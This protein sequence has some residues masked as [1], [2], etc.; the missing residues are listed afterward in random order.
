MDFSD[1]EA[2]WWLPDT[3]HHRTSG[4]LAYSASGLTLTV[5]G[6]LHPGVAPEPGVL[7][8]LF[9]DLKNSPIVHGETRTGQLMSLVGVSGYS[10]QMLQSFQESYRVELALEGDHIEEVTFAGIKASFQQLDVWAGAD[11]IYTKTL[12]QKTI[13]VHPETV[14]LVCASLQDATLRIKYGVEG[15]SHDKEVSY[16]RWCTY[17]AETSCSM[18]WRDL[19]EQYVQPLNDLLV[20]TMGSPIPLNDVALKV[21]DSWCPVYFRTRETRGGSKIHRPDGY[22]SPAILT[23]PTSPMPADQLLV[24]WFEIRAELRETLGVLLGPVYAP[25]TYE[26]HKFASFFQGLE[27][28]HSVRRTRYG[29]TD[30]TKAEHKERVAAVLA[31]L[32]QADHEEDVLKWAQ[33]L[34][35]PRNDKPLWR[36]VDDIVR[37]AEIVGEDILAA[38]PNFCTDV[39]RARTGVSHGGADKGL[40]IVSRYWHAEAIFWI[41]RVRIL[42][43]IGIKDVPERARKRQAY[44]FMLT[45]LREGTMENSSQS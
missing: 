39:A 27:A 35:Q 22:D 11:S 6:A 40:N 28:Y 2:S 16:N 45:K 21:N 17:S 3:P 29:T 43:D 41:M 44:Q 5:Y 12:G 8:P 26:E 42:L 25:F 1:V 34:L 9:Y 31:T 10:S 24:S 19:L 30:V 32:G 36:K 18:E 37:S 15:H 38:A 14:E 33:N 7:T 23:L 20:V 4:T 13:M